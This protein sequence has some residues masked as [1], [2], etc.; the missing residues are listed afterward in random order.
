MVESQVCSV[1]RHLVEVVHVQLAN[2]AVEIVV[3][4]VSRKQ[5]LYEVNSVE[6][7]ERRSVVRPFNNL[8]VCVLSQNTV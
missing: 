3:L 5:D 1:A 8:V 6:D 4:E 7:C 2:K